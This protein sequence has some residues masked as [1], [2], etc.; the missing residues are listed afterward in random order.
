[1]NGDPQKSELQDLI[2][3]ALK[4]EGFAGDMDA[5][6][7]KVLSNPDG[8]ESIYRTL[9]SAGF[10]GS[11]KDLVYVFGVNP[12]K[13]ESAISSDYYTGIGLP[14]GDTGV[15]DPRDTQTAADVQAQ[16]E[17]S[18]VDFLQGLFGDNAEYGLGDLDPDPYIALQQTDKPG[19]AIKY[20]AEDAKAFY[21]REMASVR[22]A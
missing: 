17:A 13:K 22:E 15:E 9:D 3:Q 12:K 14:S 16:A 4:V 18:R 10:K 20:T 19:T 6:K 11:R 7:D 1:M 8:F 5:L 2:F 21:E